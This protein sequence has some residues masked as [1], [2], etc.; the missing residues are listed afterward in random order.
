MLIIMPCY[1][2]HSVICMLE[3]QLHYKSEVWDLR[4]AKRLRPAFRLLRLVLKVNRLS[5]ISS[6]FGPLRLDDL[7]PFL[8]INN[9]L[10]LI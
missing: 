3:T 2:V 5:L 1:Q 8:P 9:T 10:S 7:Y 4:L 6:G